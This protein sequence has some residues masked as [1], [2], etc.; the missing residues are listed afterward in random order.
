M[1]DPPP[2]PPGPD[3]SPRTLLDTAARLGAMV[4]VEQRAFEVL[5]VWS[6]E[7]ADPEAQVLYATQARHHAWRADQLADRFPAIADL[8]LADRLVP[9]GD[10][11]VTLFDALA[12]L[13]ATSTVDRLAGAYRVLLPQVLADHEV[14]LARTTAVADAPLRRTLRQVIAD[15]RDDLANGE[16]VLEARLDAG[17]DVAMAVGALV[18]RLTGI[19]DGVG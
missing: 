10:A 9:P 13:D 18:T 5:S 19:L 16:A 3:T 14:D 12:A 2:A 11:V 1:T 7:P 15:E 4:W 6:R 17:P 8:A